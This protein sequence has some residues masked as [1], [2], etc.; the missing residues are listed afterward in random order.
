MQTSSQGASV[1]MPMKS[2]MNHVPKTSVHC[3]GDDVGPNP[4][5]GAGRSTQHA[6]SERGS[7]EQEAVSGDGQVER[8]TQAPPQWENHGGIR[9]GKG[10]QVE[11]PPRHVLGQQA[12][13]GSAGSPQL[14]QDQGQNRAGLEQQGGPAEQEQG[15]KAQPGRQIPQTDASPGFKQLC[16]V[17]GAQPE[18]DVAPGH[19][20]ET[21]LHCQCRVHRSNVADQRFTPCRPCRRI[22]GRAG[23]MP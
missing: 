10:K 20:Q 1:T 11:K 7:H 22:G 23:S 15:A 17:P 12:R 19:Q 8:A 4:V 6:R 16:G 14:Q 9:N 3:S 18:G 2:P 5:Q 21:T 13:P